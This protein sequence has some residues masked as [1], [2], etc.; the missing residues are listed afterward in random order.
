MSFFNKKKMPEK[1]KETKFKVV[2]G[3]DNGDSVTTGWRSTEKEA[4]KELE[5]IK[6]TK[7]KYFSSKGG[8]LF[9][10]MKKINY[11]IVIESN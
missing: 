4:K 11:A 5:E 1:K 3:L 9:V 10:E 8:R 2:I 7:S 6:Q